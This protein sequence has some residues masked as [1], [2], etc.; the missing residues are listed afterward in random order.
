MTK[1]ITIRKGLNINMKGSADK[2]I[3]PL[4]P[5]FFAIKPTDFTGI[6]PKLLVNE[7]SAVKA[8]TPLFFDKYNEQVLFT[9]PVSGKV[10]AINRG[11]RRVIEEIV[12]ERDHEQQFESFPQSNP[13]TLSS[14]KIKE[15]LLQSGNWPSIRQRPYGIIAN[16]RH[17]PDAIFISAFDTA[18]LAPDYDFLLHEKGEAFQTGIDA[19]KKLTAAPIYLNIHQT[20]TNAKEFLDINGVIINRFKGP[21]P[22]GNVGIQIHHI[23]P[24]NKGDVIWHI[25]P[26]DV[27]VIGRLFL[28]GRY[29]T[30]SLFALAGSEVINTRYFKTYKGALITPMIDNNIR[31]GNLR[32][33]SGNVLTGKKISAEGYIGYY[34]R[35]VTVIPEGD[36]Y[37]FFGWLKP[38]F[39]TFSDH[40][41]FPSKI[42]FPNKAYRLDTNLHGGHRSFIM[43]GEYESVL[44]MDIMPVQLLKAI[45]AKDIELMEQLG[46]YE[47]DEEDF[48]LCEVICTS[49][50]EVQSIIREGLDLMRKEMS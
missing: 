21:H 12:I 19:L 41:A 8:G 48:A 46:I 18:P 23:R 28:E 22:S 40:Y 14:G 15:L 32:F 5:Q 29:N 33:I 35:M 10:S 1:V 49:K 9:S 50:T 31:E 11:L 20:E 37:S 42:L 47:V 4:Q 30:E 45:L 17:T 7:G 3:Q 24:V 27:V 6:F 44:P 26:V 13:E 25:N 16:P 34:H 2:V 36:Y 38:G 39:N 43:S